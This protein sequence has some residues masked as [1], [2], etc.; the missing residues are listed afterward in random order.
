MPSFIMAKLVSV[1]FATASPTSFG[2]G[3]F[4]KPTSSLGVVSAM[5]LELMWLFL[6]WLEM[7]IDVMLLE[8][9]STGKEEKWNHEKMITDARRREKH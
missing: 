4:S 7:A 5:V 9:T 3:A 1:A 2:H 8:I 6:P